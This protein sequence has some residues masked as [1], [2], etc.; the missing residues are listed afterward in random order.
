MLD[1]ERISGEGGANNI[2]YGRFNVNDIDRI[3]I[4]RGAAATLYDS[5]AIGG[6]INIIT[7]KG[8]RPVTARV[9]TRYAGRN[10]EMYSVSAGVNRKNFSA[11]TSFGYRKRES[12]TIADLSLIHISEPT[13][14]Y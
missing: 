14:P 2:D 5:R 7:R 3:E 13:R 9:S 12:Y 6:V 8:F 1:G 11:L 10:G 4:V